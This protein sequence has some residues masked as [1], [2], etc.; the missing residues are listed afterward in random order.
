[1]IDAACRIADRVI[2]GETALHRRVRR[3]GILAVAILSFVVIYRMIS[4]GPP[5]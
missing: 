1:M 2:R 5:Y 4:A 3:E